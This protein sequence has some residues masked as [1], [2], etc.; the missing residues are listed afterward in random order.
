MVAGAA[1]LFAL[2]SYVWPRQRQVDPST[3]TV[4]AEVQEADSADVDVAVAAARAAFEG[5]EWGSLPASGRRM[6]MLRLADLIERDREYLM[7]IESLDNGKPIAA[8]MTM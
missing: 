2:R 8:D 7:A 3:E 1:R 5:P 4:I 6:L